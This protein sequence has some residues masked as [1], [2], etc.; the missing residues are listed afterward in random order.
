MQ[1]TLS[2]EHEPRPKGVKGSGSP[3]LPLS[4]YVH[5]PWALEGF[6]MNRTG[7]VF[8][9]FLFGYPHL[10]EGVQGGED[11]ATV[12]M[13]RHY[14][15]VPVGWASCHPW[16]LR[17][18]ILSLEKDTIVSPS[19]PPPTPFC[20][21]PIS[22]DPC[23]VQPFLRSGDLGGGHGFVSTCAHTAAALT[24]QAARARVVGR[25]GEWKWV[26]GAS[27]P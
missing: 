16:V 17:S 19:Q 3:F 2:L 23:G 10:L 24:P 11:G 22:P 18:A 26:Q 21:S 14:S 5:L 1:G 27:P 15:L 4:Q 6:A 9:I 25:S 20:L 8:F 12:R 13:E 7:T